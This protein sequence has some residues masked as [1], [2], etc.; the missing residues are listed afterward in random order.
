[1][2]TTFPCIFFEEL[3]AQVLRLLFLIVFVSLRLYYKLFTYVPKTPVWNL[4]DYWNL[5]TESTRNNPLHTTHGKIAYIVS[6]QN[7]LKSILQTTKFTSSK[8]LLSVYQ[9]ADALTINRKYYFNA[10][11]QLQ[12]KRIRL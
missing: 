11:H 12:V 4:F 6:D 3:S 7:M 9:Q 8:V 1:M 5:H 10:G 2:V